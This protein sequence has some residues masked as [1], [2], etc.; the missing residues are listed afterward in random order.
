MRNISK[1]NTIIHNECVRKF[2]D[3]PAQ[4]LQPN[5]LLR[6][7][8]LDWAI[9]G[10]ELS[11]TKI[12]REYERLTGVSVGRNRVCN[13]IS[14]LGA[15]TIKKL[16]NGL[17]VVCIISA[18]ILGQLT[19][20]AIFPIIKDYYFSTVYASEG[21]EQVEAQAGQTLSPT[22]STDWEEFVLAVEKIAPIYG[23]PKNVVLAQGALESSR[24]NS[25]FAKERNNFLG[26]GAFDSNPGNAY[27]FDNAEQCVIEYMRIIRKNFPEAW[28]NRDNPEQLLHH[29][30]HNDRGMMYATDPDYISKVKSMKEWN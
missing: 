10:K 18:T 14:K 1:Y 8:I 13:L 22:P 30:K 6:E 20:K 27:T 3:P 12:A 11:P 19:V 23:F 2:I 16:R 21:V 9:D 26:I 4:G 24:G 25:T 7:I 17:L 29:L 28:A 15:K 5:Y